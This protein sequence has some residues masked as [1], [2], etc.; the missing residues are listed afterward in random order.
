MN[1]RQ[2][3]FDILE[4]RI[5]M[6]TYTVTNGLESDFGSF[7]QAILSANAHP[8]LDTIDF[9]VPIPG[10]KVYTPASPLPMI[11]DPVV[12]DGTTQPGWSPGHPAIELRGSPGL[13]ANGA[14]HITGGNSTVRGLIF[15]QWGFGGLPQTLWLHN[16]DNNVVEGCW[17]GIDGLT[18]TTAAPNNDDI[19]STNSS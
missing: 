3:H 4:S 11:T 5:C 7:R 10:H 16:G 9:N 15:T 13:A 12:I 17:F 1:T 14:L 8:G 19:V 6:S 2:H 18:G